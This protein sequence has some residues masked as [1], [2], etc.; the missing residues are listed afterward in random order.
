VNYFPKNLHKIGVI[1]C[2]GMFRMAVDLQLEHC[3]ILLFPFIYA[4]HKHKWLLDNYLKK[5]HMY[6]EKYVERFSI[7]LSSTLTSRG[8]VCNYAFFLHWHVV[9]FKCRALY[10]RVYCRWWWFVQVILRYV[11]SISFYEKK[12]KFMLLALIFTIGKV[13]DIEM[14]LCYKCTWRFNQNFLLRNHPPSTRFLHKIHIVSTT[15]KVNIHV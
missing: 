3:N 6:P 5:R 11:Y 7:V 15:K 13:H 10:F 8:R 14:L 2:C 12:F 9:L 4:T 1:S